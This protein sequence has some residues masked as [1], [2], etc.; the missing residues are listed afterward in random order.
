MLLRFLQANPMVRLVLPLVLGILVGNFI[1]FSLFWIG[2]IAVFLF[3]ILLIVSLLQWNTRYGYG[4]LIALLFCCLGIFSV[5]ST[6]NEYRPPKELDTHFA[7]AIIR[8]IPSEKENNVSVILEIRQ[9]SRKQHIEQTHFKSLAYFPK[10]SH[11]QKWKYGDTLLTKLE[12]SSLPK[13]QNPNA[14][15]YG[16]WLKTQQIY[17]TSRGKTAYI[18]HFV[19]TDFS[20]IR[21]AQTLQ[22]KF[23]AILEEYIKDKE[24]VGFLQALTLGNKTGLSAELR[25]DFTKAGVVHILA[26][27]G[28]HIGILFLLVNFVFQSLRKTRKRRFVLLVIGLCVI[29]SFAFISGLSIS[30]LRA[31]VMFSILQLSIL[32]LRPYRIY[33]TIATSMLLLLLINPFYLY[34]VGFQLSYF[35]VLSIVTFV[36]MCTQKELKNKYLEY[37]RQLFFVSISAQLGVAPLVLYYFHQLPTYFLLGNLLLLNLAPFLL[38]GSLLILLCSKIPFLAQIIAFIVLWLARFCLFIVNGITELP[39]AILLNYSLDFYQLLLLCAVGIS[40]IFYVLKRN[41]RYF[42]S[43]L[44]VLMLFVGYTVFRNNTQNKQTFFVIH[45]VRGKSCYNLITEKKSLLFT[46]DKLEDNEIKYAINPFLEAHNTKIVEICKIGTSDEKKLGNS[47]YKKGVFFVNGKYIISA[48]GK[49]G[50]LENKQKV[51]ILIL[52]KR[53]NWELILENY[54]PTLIILDS[55]FSKRKSQKLYE[56]LSALKYHVYNVNTDGAFVLN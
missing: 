40:S 55:S 18:Q 27:S 11:F 15:D 29:W 22:Q 7:K 42:T 46:T 50:K 25:D 12:F 16:E 54:A 51:A 36:P 33:N 13:P 30:V 2:G 28:L 43:V 23:S 53:D 6:Q 21:I 34:E 32:S 1:D 41:I 8:S 20:L 31:S 52:S 14:F 37:F 9:L 3:F 38:G 17:T 56:E 44:I 45:Y 39:H 35:A 47:F 49:N 19:A 48:K 4:I 24:V 26:V 10:D 5:L